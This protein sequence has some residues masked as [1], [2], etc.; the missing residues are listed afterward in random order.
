[1][2]SEHHWELLRE[3]RSIGLAVNQDLSARFR[4]IG[5]SASAMEVL[6]RLDRTPGLSLAGLGRNL[7]LRKQSLHKVLRELERDQLVFRHFFF[8]DS[9]A[10][11]YSLTDAGR[12]QLEAGRRL[13]ADL[14]LQLQSWLGGRDAQTLFFF[15]HKAQHALQ[16]ARR[17]RLSTEVAWEGAADR[18]G[19]RE[20]VTS[21]ARI[22]CPVPE[23]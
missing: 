18:A 1:M 2:S 20:A 22:R 5:A 10:V 23:R 9:R 7:D 19:E 13:A 15:L 4:S 8:H 14:E 17:M 11:A 16:L 6:E 21:L 12:E 3:L